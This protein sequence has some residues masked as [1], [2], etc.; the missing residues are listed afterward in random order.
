MDADK[1]TSSERF[2]KAVEWLERQLSFDQRNLKARIDELEEQLRKMPRTKT[3]HGGETV[4]IWPSQEDE[5]KRQLDDLKKRLELKYRCEDADTFYILKKMNGK[6]AEE[7]MLA[8]DNVAFWED[9]EEFL[10]QDPHILWFLKEIGLENNNFFLKE[11]K[12]IAQG[13]SVQGFINS[14]RFN[15]AGPLRVFVATAPESDTTLKALD[16][17]LKNW[18]E[19]VTGAGTIAI[20]I[21]ALAELDSERYSDAI[22]EEVDYLKRLQNDDGSWGLVILQPYSKQGSIENTSLAIWAISEINSNIDDAVMKGLKW[23]AEKQER[24]GS[25]GDDSSLTVYA[26]LALLAAGEG[27]KISAEF[28]DCQ[29]LRR[30]QSMRRQRAQFVHTSPL[31]QGSLHVKE[32]H[33]KV[34]KMLR[35]AKKEIR[36]A[37]PFIDMLYEEIIDLKQENPN[38][39]VKIITRPKKEAEGLREKIAK[40]VIDILSIASKGNVVQS[41]LIH[42]RIIIV[43][44]EEV[45][46]SSA[47]L[48]RDQLFDEFNA[49]IST[50]DKEA[51]KKAIDFFE[52][53]FAMEKKPS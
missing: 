27:P 6:T 32:I 28:A 7:F 24:D 38:L 51:V 8:A 11:T 36:I 34:L 15:H 44:D 20:G 30:D 49:G 42:A 29:K 26:L 43:D 39:S 13:Q 22:K 3:I 12:S 52:N 48:T 16:Y 41:D 5:I 1:S 9:A 46:V 17:W 21:L 18:K 10:L 33:S 23:L 40:N 53:V 14:N 31:Y 45:L 25:W 35:N 19:T 37:S 50:R 2:L 47:D 4:Q